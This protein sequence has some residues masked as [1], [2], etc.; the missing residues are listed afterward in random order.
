MIHIYFLVLRQPVSKVLRKYEV[1]DKTAKQQ[2]VLCLLGPNLSSSG[3]NSRI[4]SYQ[5]L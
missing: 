1:A 4:F 2:T 5:L 3:F